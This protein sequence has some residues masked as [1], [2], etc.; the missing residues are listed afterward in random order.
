MERFWVYLDNKVQGPVD[1]PSL[2]KLSG[3]NLLTQ[4]CAEGQESWRMADEVI[5]IKAY[6][7]S[8]PRGS[9]LMPEVQP[10]LPSM[11]RS[12]M[13]MPAMS[14]DTLVE[15]LPDDPI[16]VQGNTLTQAEPAPAPNGLRIA[17]MT[18]GYKN[19][20]DVAICMKCGGPLKAAAAAADQKPPISLNALADLPSKMETSA[21]L[22]IEESL[23][24]APLEQRTESPMV[25]IPIKRIAII[26][27]SVVVAGGLVLGVRHFWKAKHK[28][29]K[30]LKPVAV[31]TPAP[32]VSR[33]EGSKPPARPTRRA[34]KAAAAALPGVSAATPSSEEKKAPKTE[35]V[36]S[37]TVLNQAYPLQHRTPA[38]V[39]SKYAV[40]RRGEAGLWAN[41]EEEAIQRAQNWRIYGGQRTIRRNTE[42]LMQIL[43]DREYSSAFESG[44]RIHLFNDVDWAASPKEGPIYEVRLTLS[45]G[46][47]ADGSPRAPLRFAFNADLE[48]QTV[49]PGGS[50]AIKANTVHAFFDESRIPPEERRS[51]AKDTE[52]LVRAAQ[53]GE[54]PL[55]LETI[56]KSYAATYSFPALS[57]VAEAYGLTIVNKK[58][59]RETSSVKDLLGDAPT[60]AAAASATAAIAPRTDKPETGAAPRTKKAVTSKS[61]TI[62]YTM[63]R[64][65]GKERLV[66]AEAPSKATPARLWETVTSYDRWSQFIPDVLSSKREGQDGQ[67]VI[68]HTVTLTRLMFFVFKVNVHLRILEHPQ[69]RRL[70]FERIA[71]DFEKFSGHIEIVSDPTNTRST[72]KL[73]VTLAPKGRVPNWAVRGMGEHF[74]VPVLEAIRTKA[75]SN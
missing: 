49:Q 64:G 21:P 4:V 52:S 6:F 39:D 57:R 18:C 69:Q 7:S 35:A 17:C 63:E 19:P 31:T 34:P 75:E 54:S 43:R 38:P 72:L 28:T 2:R 1:I 22:K 61:G 11:E 29:K 25:E 60:S 51:V 55:A 36:A 3:F 48:R 59:A 74:L 9:S 68:V 32:K 50:G 58:L 62:Q 5:E 53:P 56:T 30:V 24:A 37:Y 67:A 45:G 14:M 44:K 73:N 40:K 20:R 8:P 33:S 23:T 70:E 42:I 16:V 10:E 15:T 13:P 46:K 41:R 27:L 47:E 26:L 66:T 65:N 12:Q 71:G